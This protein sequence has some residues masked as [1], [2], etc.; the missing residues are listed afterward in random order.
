MSVALTCEFAVIMALTWENSCTGFSL[1]SAIF[2][3]HAPWMCP[4]WALCDV[5]RA[6]PLPSAAWIRFVLATPLVG[7][8]A[9]SSR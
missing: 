1:V 5:V 6:P 2:R 4:R 7:P 8:T 3:P 9:K